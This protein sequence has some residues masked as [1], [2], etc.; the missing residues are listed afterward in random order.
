MPIPRSRTRTAYGAAVAALVAVAVAGCSSHPGRHLAPQTHRAAASQP[1]QQPTPVAVADTPVTGAAAALVTALKTDTGVLGPDW[2][3]DAKADALAMIDGPGLIHPCGHTTPAAASGRQVL[4]AQQTIPMGAT[5]AVDI[6][7]YP[8]AAE[9]ATVAQGV[10]HLFDRCGHYAAPGGSMAGL[11][12]AVA[13]SA[14]PVSGAVAKHLTYTDPHAT[15]GLEASAE[16]SLYV[17]AQGDHVITLLVGGGE[18]DDLDTFSRDR[19]TS[20]LRN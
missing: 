15:A 3:L 16:Y 20:L 1:A 2:Q 5:A 17:A 19:L 13:D 12:V 6:A 10:G 9:A 18:G 14:A 4:G 11:D 7:Q 8:T